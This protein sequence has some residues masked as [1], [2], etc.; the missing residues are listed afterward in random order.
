MPHAM[1]PTTPDG[2]YFVVHSRRR[3]A[4]SPAGAWVGA[5]TFLRGLC[6]FADERFRNRRIDP[7]KIYGVYTSAFQPSVFDQ[8]KQ[9]LIFFCSG[10]LRLGQ[11]SVVA[12]GVHLEGLAK[13]PHRVISRVLLDEG[14]LQPHS[15]AK[16]AAAFFKM[17][18]SSVTR[19]SSARRLR[20]SAC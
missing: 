2:R 5:I 10:R 8:T 9:A 14:V 6:A 4:A 20:S 11:P 17:S 15:L 16:Y 18:R 19:L 12:A 3:A 7:G 1:C 13:A